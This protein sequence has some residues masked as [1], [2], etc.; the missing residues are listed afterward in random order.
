MFASHWIFVATIAEIPE[1]GDFVTVEIGSYSIIVVHD[2][3]GVRALHNV[4]RHR[5][6]RVL[7][8]PRGSVGNLV[9]GYHQWTYAT[10]G[11]LLHA[12]DQ[13]AGFDSSCFGLK[14]VNV[15]TVDGL[16]FICLADDPPSDFDDV[17]ARI[18][19]YFTAHQ[20]HRMKVA[21]QED[22]IEQGNWKL[23]MENNRECYHCE[24]NHPELT[25]TFFPTYGYAPDKIPSPAPQR[26]RALCRGRSRTRKGL[27]PARY[28]V[29]RDRGTDDR[30]PASES[31]GKR[32][33][34]VG[35]SYTRDGSAACRRLV[36]ELDNPRMGRLTLHTQPN[37]WMHFLVRSRHHLH[38]AAHRPRPDAGAHHLAGARGR[39]GGHRLR[40]RQAHRCLAP[41]QRP[42][43]CTRRPRSYRNHQ[44][45]LQSRAV[46]TE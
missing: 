41:H 26:A 21:A 36:G 34:A 20:L 11:A 44:S 12:A 15:R 28:A 17:A 1:P 23:V 30:P 42:R 2:D 40:P 25:R 29:R 39:R 5:G 45:G 18:A 27:H 35:E 43:Q 24:G 14:R 16:I 32:W 31:N 10:D 38:R 37:S 22:I 33:T 8:E 19:P 9:C 6:A 3:D 13:P 4:C 46:R 7:L